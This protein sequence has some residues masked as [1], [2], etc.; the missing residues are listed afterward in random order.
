MVA[1]HGRAA[2]HGVARVVAEEQA[3]S[4][5][6]SGVLDTVNGQEIAQLSDSEEEEEKE[7]GR[8]EIDLCS[9]DEVE[10]EPPAKRRREEHPRD[11]PPPSLPAWVQEYLT[12]GY[13]LSVQWRLTGREEAAK[14]LER[15]T[16]LWNGSSASAAS[17]HEQ[18]DVGAGMGAGQTLGGRAATTDGMSE[19]E[20]RLAALER[21]GQ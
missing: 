16:R 18:R 3:S 6:A 10:G 9:D 5:S 1:F 8:V 11:G 13:R 4:S 15:D 7:D 2:L 12:R 21:R 17:S 19:R 14:H 20:M